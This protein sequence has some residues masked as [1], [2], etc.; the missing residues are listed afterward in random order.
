MRLEDGV[1]DG[2][3]AGDVPFG[4]GEGRGVAAAAVLHEGISSAMREEAR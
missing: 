3:G 1:A 2:V 4:G